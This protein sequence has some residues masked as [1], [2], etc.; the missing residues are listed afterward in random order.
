MFARVLVDVS[1]GSRRQLVSLRAYARHRQQLGLVGQ[2]L[3]AVRK[4]IASGRITAIEGKIDPEVAD[5]QW[6]AHTD[7][8][9][10]ARGA[11]GGHAPKPV[12]SGQVE[13]MPG[14][15]GVSTGRGAYFDERA[16]REK[17][18]ADMAEIELARLRGELVPLSEVH[19]DARGLAGELVQQME[20]IPDRIGAEFGT[21]DAN[22][23]A[24][25]RRLQEEFDRLR[26]SITR[27]KFN[28][29][30]GA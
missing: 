8:V 25:R 3:P 24:L 21:D 7:A 16:R 30:E 29:A 27:C 2:T 11:R 12:P 6:A 1:T 15:F 18:E 22:R 17:I 4:A 28:G 20:A 19:A 5:I 13:A 23:R 26:A 9:Q 14:P 10:Q